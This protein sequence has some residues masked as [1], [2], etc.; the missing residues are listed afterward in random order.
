M[1]TYDLAVI[2]KRIYD[3][4]LPFFTLSVLR[5]ISGVKKESTMFNMVKR[6]LKSGVLLKIEKNKY[7]LKDAKIH[8]FTLA[9]LLYQPS[10]I[11]FET[12]LNF[13]GI[14]SQFPYE[15]LSSTPKKTIK[16]TF[17]GKSFIYIHLK[18]ELFW[19]YEKKE[20]FLIALPEK[21]LL[22]LLY[23]ASKG[24]KSLNIDEYNLSFINLPKFKDYLRRY[25][26]TRQFNKTINSLK[27][28]FKL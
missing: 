25:P 12:A 24:L 14:L 6:L 17:D 22:D 9:N 1:E 27:R 23:L 10:Y 26:S 21:A 15:I 19:G 16:K 5:D 2:T 3:C 18:K 7:I 20:E 8:D 4:S 28:Y 11:S 13:Y